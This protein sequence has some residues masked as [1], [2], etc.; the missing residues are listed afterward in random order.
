MSAA[1]KI[2]SA[3]TELVM[4]EPFWAVLALKL[5]VRADPTCDTGWTDGE[6][7]AYCPKWVESLTDR[8]VRGFIA[9]E[10]AHCA[11]GHPWRRDARSP[12][13]WNHA[14]DYAINCILLKAGF[15]LPPNGLCKPEYNGL[16]AEAIYAQLQSDDSGSGKGSGDKPSDDPGQIN[17][18]A[19]D[20]STDPGQCGETRDCKAEGPDTD[21]QAEWQQAVIEAE[22][23]SK[24]SVPAGMARAIVEA[25][26]PSCRDLVAAVLE[27][28]QRMSANDYSWRTPSRRFM[29]TG[30]Y[31]PMLKTP[32]V[33]R[34][35][36]AVD[37]S[38][39]IGAEHLS[40]FVDALQRVLDECNPEAMTVMACDARITMTREY[41]PGDKIGSSYPGGGGT[42]FVPVFESLAADPPCGAIYLTDL[43]GAFP[44]KAPEY[45]VLWVVRDSHSQRL[46][47]PFGEVI[48]LA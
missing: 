26:S 4:A 29:A 37:T 19:Q 47:V 32:A 24:G 8:Q 27:W 42:S 34:I 20:K 35:A 25:K 40:A 2:K 17:D 45:P 23:M 46:K 6:T 15:H 28:T 38:G 10:V 1:S 43:L 30:L 7:L 5:T 16:S 21:K 13:K 3:M 18:Q 36:A 41:A 39:S 12:S 14:C 22:K 9:H 31:M 48:Y 44:T 33:P 11:F